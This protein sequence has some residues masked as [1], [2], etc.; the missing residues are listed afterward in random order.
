MLLKTKRKLTMTGRNNTKQI[1]RFHV[2]L[3]PILWARR[4]NRWY[5]LECPTAFPF[6]NGSFPNSWWAINPMTPSLLPWEGLMRVLLIPKYEICSTVSMHFKLDLS[7]WFSGIAVNCM[8][9]RWFYY[10]L[11]LLRW[12][13]LGRVQ[14][15]LLMAI[16]ASMW[17]PP[18]WKGSQLIWKQRQ[19]MG[20]KRQNLD[21]VF[22]TWDPWVP[23]TVLMLFGR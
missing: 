14:S 4:H 13:V 3:H 5:F 6:R 10:F 2:C 23:G 9:K 22:L 8:R 7:D 18:V 19:E 21:G 16:V 12:L 1:H 11:F 20:W 15:K 17:W